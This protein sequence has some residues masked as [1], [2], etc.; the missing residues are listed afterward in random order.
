MLNKIFEGPLDYLKYVLL[1][2]WKQVF[3]VLKTVVM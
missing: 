2:S 1:P 3:L